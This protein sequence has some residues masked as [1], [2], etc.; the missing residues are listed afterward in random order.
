[1]TTTMQIGEK[2]KEID[3]EAKETVMEAARRQGLY[4]DAPCGGR[5]S[6]GKCRVL[7]MRRGT[8]LQ[9]ILACQM[10][11]AQLINLQLRQPFDLICQKAACGGQTEKKRS[12]RL[13]QDALQGGVP[14]SK[15]KDRRFGAAFDIGTTTIAAMLWDLD[16]WESGIPLATAAAA[17]PQAAYGAD[18]I[19]RVQ[20]AA[21]DREKTAQ[22]QKMVVECINQLICQLCAQVEG[23]FPERMLR[24]CAVGNTA[25]MQL[26]FGKDPAGLARA[27][28][29]V[30][31]LPLSVPAAELGLCSKDGAQL[32]TLPCMGGHLGADAAAVLLAL[33][34]PLLRR[35][36]IALDIGTNGEILLTD[37]SGRLWGCSA[38]AGPAFEGADIS[39][40]MRGEEGAIEGVEI[41]ETGKG[42][43]LHVIGKTEA[44]GIC[45]SGLI[46]AAAV[47]L[48]LRW[49]DETG[50]LQLPE[51]PSATRVELAGNVALT[52]R[53]IRQMQTAKA[54]IAAGAEILLKTAGISAGQLSRVCLAGAF[55]SYL[56]AES[57]QAIGLL[58]GSGNGTVEIC[59]NAAGI[60]A[61]LILLSQA[62]WERGCRWAGQLAH[63]ELAQQEEFADIF[64]DAMY[65]PKSLELHPR[66]KT[67]ILYS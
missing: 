63:V 38:A 19:S 32:R 24:Y 34:M 52:Q 42:L 17:N 18:V 53:D 4:I 3:I 8:A 6:C 1:M 31:A 7:L 46:D 62:E 56:R 11:G 12:I 50:R 27:P 30:S 41:D 35:P 58:P 28:F 51:E 39:C 37:G 29:S 14:A 67:G 22:L 5:G 23:A 9:E 64:L 54:A 61:S 45:G 49:L 10:T 2:R 15:E 65:F 48:R 55:G 20:Y 47:M 25:M 26:L 43:K 57:A 21:G 33:R 16:C 44:K 59:G 40:G 13:P 66:G 36:A 60:G